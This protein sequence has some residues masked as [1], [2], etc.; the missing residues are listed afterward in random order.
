MSALG[1]PPIA[2]AWRGALRPALLVVLFWW[3]ATGVLFAMQR[4][5]LLRMSVLMVATVLAAVGAWMVAQLRDDGSAR[6]ATA[7]FFGGTLL[8]AWAMALFYAGVV[9][10]QAAPAGPAP[11]DMGA[12]AA[13]AL[14]TTSGGD[15]LALG[16]VALAAWL[17]RG[18]R[19]RA[20]FR[21]LVLF[22]CAHQLA[23]LNV[24]LGVANG[25]ADLLP[26]RLAFLGRYFG[27][28]ENS[29]LLVPSVLALGTVALWLVRRARRAALPGRRRESWL[30]AALAFVAALEHVFLGLTAAPRLWSLFLPG[31]G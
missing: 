13:E 24:F 22:W 25:G 11:A 15:L 8:W 16:A 9:V 26:P 27:P 4:G 14:A 5:V 12:R 2:P 23:R 10:G 31:R 21:A 30:L 28:A 7:S 3:G 6:A 19:N 18:G 1:R 20:G 29:W 17:A